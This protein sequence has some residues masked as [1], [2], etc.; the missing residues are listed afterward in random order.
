MWKDYS[1]KLVCKA[2][3]QKEQCDS[4]NGIT[5]SQDEKDR[6]KKQRLKNKIGAQ[7]TSIV[8]L[9]KHLN[10]NISEMTA[11][12]DGTLSEKQAK[13]IAGIKK[14]VESSISVK[15]VQTKQLDLFSAAH[16]EQPPLLSR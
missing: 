3:I 5:T 1:C 10:A 16:S 6:M 9:L 13:H 7:N 8:G 14:R 12:G 15:T 4:R 11:K 2:K